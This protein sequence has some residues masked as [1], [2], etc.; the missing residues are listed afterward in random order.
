MEHI[1]HD[2]LAPKTF[3]N[4]VPIPTQENNNTLLWFLGGITLLGLTL[5]IYRDTKKEKDS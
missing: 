3:N 1:A 2:I 5:Y 4:F